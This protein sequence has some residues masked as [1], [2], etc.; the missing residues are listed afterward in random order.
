MASES[1]PRDD[2][3]LLCP[4]YSAALTVQLCLFWDHTNV[5]FSLKP[6]LAEP[7]AWVIVKEPRPRIAP[8]YPPYIP[9]QLRHVMRWSLSAA[10]V[11]APSV[12]LTTSISVRSSQ[13]CSITSK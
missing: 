9:P 5:T 2:P 7:V 1:F 13:W 12:F 11:K 10:I 8:A 3:E 4:S 6:A